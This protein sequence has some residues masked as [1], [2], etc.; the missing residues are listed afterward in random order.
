MKK[1]EPVNFRE[2]HAKIMGFQEQIINVHG[3][4][5]K[6]NHER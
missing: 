6:E 2:M 1:N 4:I 5:M 3:E